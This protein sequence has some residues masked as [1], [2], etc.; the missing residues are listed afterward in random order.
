[1]VCI[2]KVFVCFVLFVRVFKNYYY[3]VFVLLFCLL[4][5]L[6]F[7]LLFVVC[8]VCLFVLAGCQCFIL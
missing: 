8:C 3:F 2:C 4:W 5:F 1:M 6:V 7:F